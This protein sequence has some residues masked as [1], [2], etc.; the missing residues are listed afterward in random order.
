MDSEELDDRLVIEAASGSRA[1]LERVLAS[2]TPR[3]RAM[4]ITRLAASRGS[5][6]TTEELVQNALIALADGIGRLERQSVSGLNAYVSTIVS[7]K[8]ADALR[9][10]ASGG[11][12]GL[13]SL[14]SEVFQSSIGPLWRTVAGDDPS[15]SMEAQAGELH[16]R[17]LEEL[18]RL[19]DRHREVIILSL[20]DRLDTEAI[21]GRMG[22]TRN[23]ASMLL[24][25]AVELLKGR[26]ALD[27]DVTGESGASA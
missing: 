22:L 10:P 13:R 12:A 11:G 14:D 24:L 27:G 8:V 2:L 16:V 9:A 25:R 3:L 26:L 1:A 17:M 7:H 15:P 5:F 4:V 18:G 21:G 20:V 6:Q 19:S 23:G